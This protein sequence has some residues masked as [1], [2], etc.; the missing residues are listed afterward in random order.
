MGLQ[1]LA[2]HIVKPLVVNL[3]NISAFL[4]MLIRTLLQ[5]FPPGVSF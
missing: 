1:M 4:S 3:T 5:T 2:Y